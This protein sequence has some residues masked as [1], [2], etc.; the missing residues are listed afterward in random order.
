MITLI[1]GQKVT[2]ASWGTPGRFFVGS[3]ID[4]SVDKG[5]AMIQ[6]R[7]HM[8]PRPVALS[9]LANAAYDVNVTPREAPL[10]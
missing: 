7:T 8:P 2:W 5:V 3:L 6:D 9:R 1:S 10:L 4:W